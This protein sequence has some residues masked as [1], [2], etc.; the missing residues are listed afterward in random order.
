MNTPNPKDQFIAAVRSEGYTATTLQARLDAGGWRGSGNRVW[1]IELQGT[2]AEEEQA[3]RDAK[4]AE[5][6]DLDRR[7]LELDERNANAAESGARAGWFA[8]WGTHAGWIVALVVG[9]LGG[10]AVVY[11]VLR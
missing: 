8:A 11:Y 10:G 9:A 3:E 2:M 5:R 6:D 7:R 4:Q 1:A